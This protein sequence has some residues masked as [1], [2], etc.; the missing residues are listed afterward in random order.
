[1]VGVVNARCDPSASV[2]GSALGV[3]LR[4]SDR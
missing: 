3:H 2:A 1:M 4:R